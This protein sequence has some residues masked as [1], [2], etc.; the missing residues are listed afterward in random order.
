MTTSNPEK[1]KINLTY[2]LVQREREKVSDKEIE[3]QRKHGDLGDWEREGSCR[4][5]QRASEKLQWDSDL[6]EREGGR[7]RE[8]WAFWW[9]WERDRD[10]MFSEFLR[11]KWYFRIVEVERVFFF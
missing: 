11:P 1:Q 2:Q 9:E 7:E 3:D 4:E 6:R 10:E 8:I 5:R